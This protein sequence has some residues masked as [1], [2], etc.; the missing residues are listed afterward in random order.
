MPSHCKCV[1]VKTWLCSPR[2][3][4]Q[5]KACKSQGFESKCILGNLSEFQFD[6]SNTIH[7]LF[8]IS[9]D[10]NH[11][12]T[13]TTQYI[14]LLILVKY[15]FQILHCKLNWHFSFSHI[16]TLF[17]TTFANCVEEPYQILIAWTAPKYFAMWYQ[18][19]TSCR[20]F[21]DKNTY[22]LTEHLINP[23]MT[24]HRVVNLRPAS[25]CT[26]RLIAVYNPASIDTGIFFNTHTTNTSKYTFK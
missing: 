21:C 9:K 13:C 1:M 17:M 23:F 11:I 3:S 10:V 26:F 12:Y 22:H 19:T 2:D 8:S 5:F 14:I 16:A 7:F 6:S 20:V 18:L 25:I 24:F 15:F 4:T